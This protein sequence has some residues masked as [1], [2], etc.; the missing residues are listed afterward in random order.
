MDDLLALCKEVSTDKRAL[1]SLQLARRGSA[2]YK[3]VRGLGKTLKETTLE[4]LRLNIDES[5]SNADNR[6]LAVMVNY[7]NPV[8]NKMVAEHLAAL[9][10]VKVNTASIFAALVD[11]FNTYNLSWNLVISMLMDSCAVMRGSKQGLATR[12]RR[13]LEPHLLDVDGD[14][15]HHAN[16]ASK[17]LC[18]PFEQCSEKLANDLHTDNKWS[19]DLRE[20]LADVCSVIGIKFTMP[21]RHISHRWLSAYY[22]SLDILRLWDGYKLFYYG[23]L[24]PS[25]RATYEDVMSDI[26]RRHNVSVQQKAVT[27]KIWHDLSEKKK[28]LTEDGKKRK[29]RIFDK[30]LFQE[31][32]T[33]LVLNFYKAVLPLLKSYMCLFQSS[34]PLVHMLNDKQELLRQFLSNFVRKR[35]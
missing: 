34:E 9:E 22:R 19:V 11:L 23:F 16:N 10:L 27:Q 33:L 7:F 21:E 3:L 15:C 24:T 6:V 14:V 35:S 1:D 12:I 17:R 25:D 29:E 4:I 18:A 8:L 26:L 13:E 31:K 28:T 5:T 20:W 32:K 30:V 2:T